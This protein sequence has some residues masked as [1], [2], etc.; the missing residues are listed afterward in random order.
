MQ[1]AN[2]V[3][4]FKVPMPR[5]PARP[6]GRERYT[7]VYAIKTGG[8][9]VMVDTGVDSDAG[10]S[11][12]TQQLSHAAIALGDIALVV[13]THGHYDHFGLADKVRRLTGAPIALHRLDAAS[14]YVLPYNPR[15]GPARVDVLLEGGEELLPGSGLWTIWTPGHTPGHICIHDR[16]R[17]LLFSGDHLLPV[18]TPNVSRYPSDQGNPLKD[19]LDAHSALAKLDVVTVHPAHEH[20]FTDLKTRVREIGQHHHERAQEILNVVA[21]RPSTAGEVAARIS[22]NVGSWQDM[23]PDTRNMAMWEASAH[24]HFLV[25]EGSI[26]KT[27]IGPSALLAALVEALGT[28]RESRIALVGAGRL[29]RATAAIHEFADLGHRIVAVFDADARQVGE[30]VEGLRIQHVDD[31]AGVVAASGIDTAIVAVP[32]QYTQTAVDTLVAAGVKT[33]VNYSAASPN[34]PADVRFVHIDAL[35]ALQSSTYSAGQT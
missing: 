31:L 17:K 24:L 9:W 4:Q 27:D 13:M 34:V 33:I 35:G 28:S 5:D 21:K 12:L 22:W 1:V 32:P 25:E 11:A 2:G 14:P 23:S 29:G 7:L 16:Q 20:S 19:F 8:A 10:L 15:S 6:E 18:T 26:V 30:Q 3:E